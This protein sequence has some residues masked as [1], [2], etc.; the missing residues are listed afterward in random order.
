[1]GFPPSNSMLPKCLIRGIL[2]KGGGP[3]AL[4]FPKRAEFKEG[5]YKKALKEPPIKS[6]FKDYFGKKYTSKAKI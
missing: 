1:M 4:F 2:N 5:V 6:P 3:L